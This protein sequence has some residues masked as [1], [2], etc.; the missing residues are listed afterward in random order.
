MNYSISI[1]GSNCPDIDAA[2]AAASEFKAKLEAIGGTVSIYFSPAAAETTS[3][4]QQAGAENQ[5]P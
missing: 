3:P 1:S 5:A 2:R 4:G